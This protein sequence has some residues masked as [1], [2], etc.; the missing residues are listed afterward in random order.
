[1]SDRLQQ[2]VRA[3]VVATAPVVLLV[4][5]LV[6]PYLGNLPDTADIAEAAGAGP[7]RWGSAHLL[8]GVGIALALLMLFAVRTFL[9]HR[10]ED[11]WSFWA[12]GLATIGLGLVGFMVGAEGYGGLAAAQAGNA[13]A[14]FQELETWAIPTY[15]VANVFLG[16]GL[17]FFATAVAR[18]GVVGS[19]GRWLVIAGAVIA[20]V[21]LFLPVGWAAHV[22]SIG[23]LA[24]AW[25]VAYRMWSA[26]GEVGAP[27]AS[28]A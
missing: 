5:A 25:P 12:T 4:A 17:L 22:V 11:R 28:T 18:S 21:G 13:R 19:V 23:T 10:G 8:F 16:L 20:T 1:M 6:H 2:R 7:T 27:A 3:S 24:F 9:H 14:F 15:L 26:D